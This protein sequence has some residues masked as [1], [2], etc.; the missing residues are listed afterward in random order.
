MIVSLPQ[1][2]IGV[3]NSSLL[4]ALVLACLYV[5]DAKTTLYVKDADWFGTTILSY[6]L[7]VKKDITTVL[8]LPYLDALHPR[9]QPSLLASCPTIV[10]GRCSVKDGA[11]LAPYFNISP[12]LTQL[13][14]LAPGQA[15]AAQYG[16]P[17]HLDLTGHTFRS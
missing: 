1:G 2:Q 9:H 8:S 5:S 6:M 4:G 14:E 11:A 16:T 7:K 13:H 12:G 3:E 17:T 15:I 10:S